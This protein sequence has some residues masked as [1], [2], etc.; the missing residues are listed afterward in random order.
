MYIIDGIYSEREDYFFEDF[1][2]DLYKQRADIKREMK[3]YD[4]NSQEYSAL[5]G[6]QLRYKNLLNGSYGKFGTQLGGIVSQLTT[7]EDLI[8]D[9]FTQGQLKDIKQISETLY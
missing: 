6:L 8:R 3:K 7:N 5:D 4:K 9:L 1:V 2:K